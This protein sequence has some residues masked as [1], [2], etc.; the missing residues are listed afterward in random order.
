MRLFLLIITSIC[1]QSLPVL[2][3]DFK[4][5]SSLSQPLLL[6]ALLQKLLRI[7]FIS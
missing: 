6:L 4:E 3:S 2:A 7:I 1:L 5:G